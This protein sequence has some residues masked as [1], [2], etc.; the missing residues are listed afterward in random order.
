[1]TRFFACMRL[2]NKEALTNTHIALPYEYIMEK[3]YS[4]KPAAI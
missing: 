4:F 3:S 2:C 1:M